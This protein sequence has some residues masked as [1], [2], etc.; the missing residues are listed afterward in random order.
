[1]QRK[2]VSLLGLVGCLIGVLPA[3]VKAQD[4]S[5]PK[6][7]FDASPL[8][9]AVLNI[10]FPA[11][12]PK[13]TLLYVTIRSSSSMRYETESQI[14]IIQDNDGHFAVT[15]YYLPSGSESIDEQ[16]G[17]LY[18]ED[19]LDPNQDPADLAKLFKV[20]V[21]TVNVSDEALRGFINEL[22]HIRFPTI[23]LKPGFITVNA[24]G[25]FYQLNYWTTMGELHFDYHYPNRDADNAKPL[26][27]WMVR[28]EKAINS[29]P[30][31]AGASNADTTQKAG[32][33]LSGI[34]F[35][36]VFDLKNKPVS[37]A[38]VT[39]LDK[40]TNVRRPVIQS[41]SEGEF[42]VPDLPPGKYDVT[43]ETINPQISHTFHITI[44]AARQSGI[45][46]DG[47]RY[48]TD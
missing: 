10:K 3:T 34:L 22:D 35:G 16:M 19:K 46:V 15:Q 1:M 47:N 42:V 28:V 9:K 7:P 11:D 44:V 32:Q 25:Y 23:K 36:I 14:N 20:E 21:R 31:A 13:G 6:H 38:K 48:T 39:I 5:R 17:E 41:N 2:K 27:D 8:Y 12:P 26:G 43:V 4:Y 29:A 33:P 30:S 18:V 37:G 45:T 24:D 40:K